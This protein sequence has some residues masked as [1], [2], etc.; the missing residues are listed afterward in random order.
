MR[1]LNLLAFSCLAKPRYSS[2]SPFKAASMAILVN[3]CLNSLKPYTV[4]M[5]L[6]KDLPSACSSSLFMM[7]ASIPLAAPLFNIPYQI[8]DFSTV[9]RRYLCST[10][11][12]SKNTQTLQH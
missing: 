1:L 3:I 7:S 11:F 4:L 12:V 6:S 8:L 5:F 9:T 10:T 2:S